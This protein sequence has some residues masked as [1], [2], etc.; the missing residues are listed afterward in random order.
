[1]SI[2]LATTVLLCPKNDEE[3]VLILKIAK[4]VGIPT[5][6]SPQAHGSRLELEKDL[7]ERLKA[8]NPNAKTVVIVE[9]PG[10][11]REAE[12][13]KAGFEVVIIDHHRY[14]GL[15]RMKQE[16]SLDQF[17]VVFGL[18]DEKL[19]ELGFDPFLVKGVGMMDR[20]WVWELSREGIE[21]ADRKRIMDYYLLFLEDLGGARPEGMIE[22][23]K[24]WD[25][26]EERNGVVIVSTPT[27]TRIRESL[28][29]ILAEN[30][31]EPPV[32]IV[33]EGKHRI[34]VQDTNKAPKLLEVFGGYVFGKDLCWGY[35]S[36]PEKPGPTIDEIMKVLGS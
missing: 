10:P 36:T 14:E 27:E 3:S 24:A 29:L 16:S 11:E 19:V 30:F 25:S 33:I 20:G 31:D 1:M 21:K 6:T 15:N 23:R 26:R 34:S 2:D 17:L 4:A 35:P 7:E 28:S 32:T 13:E 22:A 9:I 12:L 18:T 8:V 5:L